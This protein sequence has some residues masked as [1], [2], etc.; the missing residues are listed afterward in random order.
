[1]TSKNGTTFTEEIS[2]PIFQMQCGAKDSTYFLVLNIF[3]NLSLSDKLFIHGKKL[4]AEK[5]IYGKYF[6]KNISSKFYYPYI[7]IKLLNFYRI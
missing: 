5:S 1:M 6:S 3:Q 2:I 4:L 7:T